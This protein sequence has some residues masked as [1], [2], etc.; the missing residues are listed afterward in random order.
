[1][2]YLRLALFP[3]AL[4]VC[5]GCNE[6]NHQSINSFDQAFSFNDGMHNWSSD[7][8]DYPTLGE[9]SLYRLNWQ[10][11]ELPL[12]GSERGLRVQ[13]NNASD[14]VFAYL[15]REFGGLRPSTNY[16]ITIEV[17]I[18]TPFSRGIGGIGGSPG[19]SNAVKIGAVAEAP[20]RVVVSVGNS[21][22]WRVSI[23]KGNQSQGGE[24]MVV[25]GSLFN[26]NES[27]QLV[28]TSVPMKNVLPHRVRSSNQGTIWAIA[29]I[30]S[31]FEGFTEVYFESIRVIAQEV[32]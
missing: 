29:G 14:D 20:A 25:V 5:F 3:I 30:D 21:T 7:F 16:D 1:M 27:D 4:T 26:G 28:W 32:P 8:V 17:T 18:Y 12:R 6:N 24:D 15:Y 2:T 19:E 31:G 23:D 10:R 22:Y 11:S 13:F 9:T